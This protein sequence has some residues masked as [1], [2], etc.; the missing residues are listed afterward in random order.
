[1]D[2]TTE[3]L[4]LMRSIVLSLVDHPHDVRI[5]AEPGDESTMIRVSTNPLDTGKLVG[6]QGRTAR[7]IR[8]ILSGHSMR[9][10]HRFA[11]DIIESRP[12]DCDQRGEG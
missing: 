2:A 1:M 6:K 9:V 8:T 10:K 3:T 12:I 5:T 7:S 11:L 4:L